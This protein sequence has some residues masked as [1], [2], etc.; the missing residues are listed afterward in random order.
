[1]VHAVIVTISR[2]SELRSQTLEDS[3][4]LLFGG[5]RFPPTV[6][7]KSV[8]YLKMHRISKDMPKLISFDGLLCIVYPSYIVLWLV[9]SIESKVFNFIGIYDECSALLELYLDS[10][11]FLDVPGIIKH[12]SKLVRIRWP[13]LMSIETKQN[14][15]IDFDLSNPADTAQPSIYYFGDS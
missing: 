1:M 7:S 4:D 13:A 15:P 5:E 8:Q 2:I 14:V 11:L 10:G 12:L 3:A 9:K 6:R